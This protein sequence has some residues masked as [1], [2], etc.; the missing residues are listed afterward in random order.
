[1]GSQGTGSGTVGGEILGARSVHDDV[2]LLG[3]NDIVLGFESGLILLGTV[4]Y[5][6][7]ELPRA[8]DL[9]DN[10]PI[11][12]KVDLLVYFMGSMRGEMKEWGKELIHVRSPARREIKL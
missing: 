1:M 12:N 4:D 6:G 11:T 2:D 10:I 5:D 8:A 9:V 7:R 3:R